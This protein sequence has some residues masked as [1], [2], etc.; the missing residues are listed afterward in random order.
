[1]E[2]GSVWVLDPGAGE[3]G[4]ARYRPPLRL[5]RPGGSTGPQPPPVGS[6]A[7]RA[8]AGGPPAGG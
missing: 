4:A 8:S 2:K 5:K 6:V 3:V 7:V 1:L